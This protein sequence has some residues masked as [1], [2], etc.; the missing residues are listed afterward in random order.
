MKKSHLIFLKLIPGCRSNADCPLTQACDKNKCIDPC[1][2]SQCGVNAICV[3]QSHKPFCSC[4]PGM[5]GEPLKG[6]DMP[7][8]P[9]RSNLQCG[10]GSLCS[11]G[12][13]ASKCVTSE[14]DCLPNQV[15]KAGVC[16]RICSTSDQCGNKQ[17]CINRMCV[18]GCTSSNDCPNNKVCY[19]NQC[20]DPCKD[21]SPCGE[22]AQ[23]AGKLKSL[24]FTV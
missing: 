13:C 4:P 7:L 2:I 17:V 5:T 11:D 22:C 1:T 20:R 18:G 23:C 15:C 16:K 8:K 10:H 6:C 24:F 19:Q 14:Q 9:C 21:D 12:V 3:T